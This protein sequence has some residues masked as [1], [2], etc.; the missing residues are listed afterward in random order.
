MTGRRLMLNEALSTKTPMFIFLYILYSNLVTLL[1][2]S[3]YRLLLK[4]E[5][6]LAV[7]HTSA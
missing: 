7:G 4:I 6:L 5:G 2:V 1:S 3:V